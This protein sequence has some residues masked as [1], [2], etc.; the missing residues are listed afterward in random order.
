MMF[1]A[2]LCKTDSQIKCNIHRPL[3][4][5][6]TYFTQLC[7]KLSRRWSDRLK[8]LI[9]LLF[10]FSYPKFCW[11]SSLAAPLADGCCCL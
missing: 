3:S 2:S 7:P 1:A 10:K 4:V 9:K 5:A 6:V 8:L 11:F